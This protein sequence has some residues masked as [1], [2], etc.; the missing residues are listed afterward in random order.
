MEQPN[1][2]LSTELVG[3]KEKNLIMTVTSKLRDVGTEIISEASVYLRSLD[4]PSFDITKLNHYSYT[5][6]FESIE[7]ALL[8]IAVLFEKNGTISNIMIREKTSVSFRSTSDFQFKHAL[9]VTREGSEGSLQPLLKEGI[10]EFVLKLNTDLDRSI[11]YQ[12]AYLRL[13]KKYV[14]FLKS[15]ELKTLFLNESMNKVGLA[16]QISSV[17]SRKRK[18]GAQAIARRRPKHQRRDIVSALKHSIEDVEATEK[19]FE[20]LSNNLNDS[21]ADNLDV[22]E[23]RSDLDSSG[24]SLKQVRL[25]RSVVNEYCSK[26]KKISRFQDEL[27]SKLKRAD[28]LSKEVEDSLLQMEEQQAIFQRSQTRSCRSSTLPSPSERRKIEADIDSF[29]PDTGS[30]THKLCHLLKSSNRV[31][32]HE[33]EWMTKL[34]QLENTP[35]NTREAMILSLAKLHPDQL[36]DI[37]L[38]NP[39]DLYAASYLSQK[40]CFLESNIQT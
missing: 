40:V 10:E 8:S 15:G 26:D 32:S 16:L 24:T 4:C 25:R 20:G 12:L 27:K 35:G 28:Q 39:K 13:T 34:E 5:I 30:L 23:V 1:R 36:P 14:I 31:F 19:A 7:N 38:R 37:V 21:D 29:I 18:R 17:I 11:E 22:R 2:L 9:I 3:S 33:L 6:T